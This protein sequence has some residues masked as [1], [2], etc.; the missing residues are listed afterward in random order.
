[1]KICAGDVV[2]ISDS[3][4]SG[5]QTFQ[6][7]ALYHDSDDSWL[8]E[9]SQKTIQNHNL[10]AF[11]FTVALLLA[12]RFD[13]TK[14]GVKAGWVW[15]DH[16]LHQF[17]ITAVVNNAPKLGDKVQ[18]TWSEGKFEGVIIGQDPED[19]GYLIHVSCGDVDGDTPFF[20]ISSHIAQRCVCKSFED[21]IGA[22]AWPQNDVRTDEAI[23]T[24]VISAERESISVAHGSMRYFTNRMFKERL[25]KARQYNNGADGETNGPSGLKFL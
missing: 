25:E 10:S 8:V 4:P 7:I 14:A 17:S 24:K 1:M 9:F 11:L 15:A 18:C 16:P 2:T 3:R 19:N 6:G 12:E 5:I 20:Y 13:A 21:K 23:I 22:W